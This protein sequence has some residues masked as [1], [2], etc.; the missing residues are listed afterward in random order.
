MTGLI[1]IYCGDGKGKTTAAIG[2]GVRACGCGIAVL[3]VQ[4]LKGE[5]SGERTAL[6]NLSDF[7]IMHNPQQIKFT[8]QMTPDELEQAKKLCGERLEAAM[9]AARNGKCGLLILDEVLD[10][11]NCD[12]IPESVLTGFLQAKPQALEVVLTGRNPSPRLLALADYVS[13][14]KKVKHPYDRRIPARKGIEY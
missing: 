9:K 3:L 11:V 4:F 12:L 6:K 14:V 13:E 2:L 5:N 1:H 10:A 7:T 8:F